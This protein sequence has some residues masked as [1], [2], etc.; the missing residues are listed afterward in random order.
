VSDEH[1]STAELAR[2]ILETPRQPLARLTTLR[3]RPCRWGEEE[4]FAQADPT[5]LAVALRV[6]AWGP[7]ASE[8]KSQTE[9]RMDES[10]EPNEP[11]EYRDPAPPVSD[12]ETL[13]DIAKKRAKQAQESSRSTLKR[14]VIAWVD[15]AAPAA[16][17]KAA[18]EGAF[19][20]EM[21]V[22]REF[23]G[24]ANDVVG[25]TLD[26]WATTRGFFST[27]KEL[28]GRD[29]RL[30]H[31]WR[32]SWADVDPLE[33]QVQN[34]ESKSKPRSA[35]LPPQGWVSWWHRAWLWLRMPGRDTAGF[36][37]MLLGAAL[38]VL[39]LL[40]VWVIRRTGP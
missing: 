20:F 30:G 34:P 33:P 14:D 28:Y 17:L 8:S 38:F 27:V 6:K 29:N 39:T 4:R 9:E 23:F 11:N 40:A 12:T 1:K 19:K 10:N 35:A 16:I 2:L 13:A 31:T 21:D 26:R 25:A 7:V 37:L 32:I 22:P 18:N 15:E 3:E 36:S 5:F 24:V